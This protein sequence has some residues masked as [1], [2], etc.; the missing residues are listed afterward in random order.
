MV[1]HHPATAEDIPALRALWKRCFEES[2]QAL[3]CL[4][5]DMPELAH[6][7]KA[8]NGDTLIAAVYLADCTLAGRPA[9]YLCGV[10]TLPEYRRKGVMTAL[11]GYALDDAKRRGDCCSVLLPA[12]DHL[13][14]YYERLGYERRCTAETVIWTADELKKAAAQEGTPD[15][16]AIQAGD[17]SALCW[18]EDYIRFAE[19]YYGCYGCRSASSDK[20]YCLYETDNDTAYVFYAIY[21][22]IPDLQA[23]LRAINAKRYVVTGSSGRLPFAESETCG[24]LRPLTDDPLPDDV[25]IGLTLN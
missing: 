14:R 22:S 3:D 15:F 25:F 16:E 23:L 13:Y 4:F 1:S 5:A 9:H 8:T 7:Y 11:M 18:S 2:E 20:A 12:D 21:T 24:M 6:I 17:D 10:A 19:R